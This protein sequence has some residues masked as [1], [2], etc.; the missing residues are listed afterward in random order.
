MHSLYIMQPGSYHKQLDSQ[1]H[2]PP[3]GQDTSVRWIIHS[4]C[5]R[6]AESLAGDTLY[7]PFSMPR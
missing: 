5:R 3:T 1:L 7:K 4:Q 6:F 2:Y